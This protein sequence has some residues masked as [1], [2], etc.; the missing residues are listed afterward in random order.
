MGK[1]IACVNE[2]GGV[3]KTTTIKNVSIG[4]ANQGKKVLA[5]DLDPSANLTKILG[6]VPENGVGAICEIFEKSIKCEDIPKGLGIVR[7]QEGIDVIT[8][9]N[10]L[11]AYETQL[12]SAMQREIVLRNYLF[13]L[14]DDYDYILVDC[15]AGLG[16]FVTNALFSADS[17]I[18]P[19][20]PHY[21]AVEAMQN[22]FKL[23]AMVRKMNGTNVKPEVLGVLFTLV[24]TNTNN[25]RN[26][27]DEL[28]KSYSGHVRVFDTY[29]PLAAKIPD[30]DLARKSIYSHA[31]NSSAAM[32]YTDLVNEI[33]RIENN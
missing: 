28:R 6:L 17:L 3:A 5:V 18:I 25:D 22:L 1:I 20:Q 15:P 24:R 10:N 14:K 12:V 4:L 31:Q 19:L 21:S 30:S 27:M 32:I 11:H 16:I 13:P 29:I 26:I 8:S 7:Q 9:S 2:K 23:I 33:L